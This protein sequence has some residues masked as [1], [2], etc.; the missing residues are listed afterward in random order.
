MR[1]EHLSHRIGSR[2]LVSRSLTRAVT[3]LR[4]TATAFAGIGDLVHTG[5]TGT[6]VNDRAVL[7]ARGGQA[8]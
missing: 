2:M 4:T 6:N 8:D 3:M 7:I 5:P 1:L